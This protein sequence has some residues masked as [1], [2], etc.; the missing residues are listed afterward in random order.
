MMRGWNGA[1]DAWCIDARLN[2]REDVPDV[3]GV[4][5]NYGNGSLL[6]RWA[7]EYIAH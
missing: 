3:E 2:R 1:A 6:D 5:Y 4:V 7:V